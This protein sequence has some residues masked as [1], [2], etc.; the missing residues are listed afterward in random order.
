[1]SARRVVI[2]GWWGISWGRG[3][4]SLLQSIL[5]KCGRAGIPRLLSKSS[6]VSTDPEQAPAEVLAQLGRPLAHEGKLAVHIGQ[7]PLQRDCQRHRV[8]L[9]CAH[10]HMNT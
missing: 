5:G 3:L 9:K 8:L 7:P 6:Q 10:L 4:S 2:G 1:M